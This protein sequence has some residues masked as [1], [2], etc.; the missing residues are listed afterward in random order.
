MIRRKPRSTLFPYTTLFRSMSEPLTGSGTTVHPVAPPSRFSNH[1]GGDRER[2]RADPQ[3]F[4]FSYAGSFL[5]NDTAQTEIYTL[6]LHDALPIYVGAIDR[7]GNHRPPSRAAFQI[8]E[9]RRRWR[10]E[11][12]KNVKISIVVIHGGV[13]S[14]EH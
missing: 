5:L 6:S 8:V 1:G 13:R 10:F 7:V 4:W 12:L 9:P 2:T 11:R 14:E 3:Y